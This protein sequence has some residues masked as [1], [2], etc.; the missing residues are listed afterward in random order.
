MKLPN[1]SG[2]RALAVAQH[3][4]GPR[5]DSTSPRLAAPPPTHPSEETQL[6]QMA[7]GPQQ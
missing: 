2:D 7:L 5:L 3:A 1:N 6:Y 4:W